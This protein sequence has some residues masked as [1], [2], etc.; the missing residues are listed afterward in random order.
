[1]NSKIRYTLRKATISDKIYFRADDVVG[2][3]FQTFKYVLFSYQVGKD[4]HLT[5]DHNENS[6]VCSVPSGS[7][8]KLDIKQ[9]TDE[10]HVSEKYNWTFDG[11]LR[12]NQQEIA[13]KLLV[14]DKLYSGLVQAGCGYGKSFLGSYLIANYG[15]STIIICHTK[16]L[17]YQWYDLL[18]Q[19]IIGADIGFIGDGKESIKPIT[20][21]I[22]KSLITRMDKIYGQFEVAITD[23]AHLCMAETFSRVV[24]G[25][26]A[27]VKLALTAT[28]VRK[29]GLHVVFPDYFGPNRVVARDEGKLM[30]SVQIIKTAIP[31]TVLNPQRDWTK[32]LTKLG[33]NVQYL[34]LLATTARDKIAHGRCILILS[35]RIDM[36]ER[37][38]ALIPRS[39]MLVG[40]T[41]SNQREEILQNAG[42]KYDAILTTKIFDEGISC[43]R[44]DTIML[45]CPNNNYAKLEQR[46]GRILR[47]H[48]DKAEPLILDFWLNGH[49]VNA[50]QKSR[51]EWY[52]KN[53]YP[54]LKN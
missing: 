26:D 50:Q 46:I 32:Q 54:I 15:K 12:E 6:G 35:E 52:L 5:I 37:L 48:P 8:H 40:S 9:L 38:N 18:K 22:Y 31:F 53:G 24:N 49:I 16:L 11:T 43:H 45:T 44:L 51:A 30:P 39:V 20:V 34:E 41:P 3:D 4:I 21:A 28:P 29:D 23:E 7:W 14:G 27:K 10:R 17:A 47:S 25:I 33:G 1:M 36:L 13:D 42:I 19:K 2:V